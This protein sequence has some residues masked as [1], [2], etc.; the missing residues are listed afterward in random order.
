[1]YEKAMMAL[2]VSSGAKDWKEDG[3]LMSEVA[4][5]ESVEIHHMVP[6]MRLKDWY[7]G[8]AQTPVALETGSPTWRRSPVQPTGDFETILRIQS[9]RN[10]TRRF[11][12]RIT[13]TSSY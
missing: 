13:L 9:L 10:T 2:V 6:E 4:Q 12:D 11:S 3:P 5:T 8:R 1:M 7:S